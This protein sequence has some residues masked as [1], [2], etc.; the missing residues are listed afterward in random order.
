MR[1][2]EEAISTFSPEF[3][4]DITPYMEELTRSV[5]KVYYVRAVD[6]GHGMVHGS[7]VIITETRYRDLANRMVDVLAKYSSSDEEECGGIH[8]AQIPV[9]ICNLSEFVSR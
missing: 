3:I 1:F 5:E 6:F 8:F 4:R 9:P 2:S 7:I